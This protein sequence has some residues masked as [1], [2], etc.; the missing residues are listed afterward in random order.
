MDGK[1]DIRSEENVGME[2][3]A[4]NRPERCEATIEFGDDFGDNT[5]TFRCQLN[6]LHSGKHVETGDM[7][8]ETCPKPYKIEWEG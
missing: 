8:E 4:A 1:D 6:K 3:V 2:M 5:A 7:G